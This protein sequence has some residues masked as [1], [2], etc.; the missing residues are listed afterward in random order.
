MIKGGTHIVLVANL[1]W[2][3]NLYHKI[4]HNPEGPSAA[5]IFKKILSF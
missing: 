5:I 1:I 2:I 4:I 3:L